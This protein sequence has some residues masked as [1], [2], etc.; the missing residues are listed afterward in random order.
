MNRS[1]PRF[2]EDIVLNPGPCEYD[3]Q[4]IQPILQKSQSFNVKGNNDLISQTKSTRMKEFNS[5]LAFPG[6]TS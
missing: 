4:K 6:P 2:I 5:N 1:N 3:N